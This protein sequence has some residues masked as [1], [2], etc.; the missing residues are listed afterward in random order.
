MLGI[1]LL[2]WWYG[3]G[4]S[5]VASS[6]PRRLH[7]TIKL[8][9]AD[10]LLRTLFAP[11]RRIVS[12][13]GK[14]LSDHFRAMIDNIISRIV[15]FLVRLSVLISAVLALVII[16]VFG[17]IELVVWPLLPLAA[18]ASLIKGILP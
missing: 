10:T 18:V 13:P 11:W 3:Q 2:T 8:F 5:Q 9:S 4:W 1:S 14:S 15:G 17:V 6:I 7:A 16:T 12:Y